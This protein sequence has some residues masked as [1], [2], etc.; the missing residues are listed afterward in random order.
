MKRV[1]IIS[2]CISFVSAVF[3]F[4]FNVP[5]AAPMTDTLSWLDPYNIV[6]T[7]PG[8]KSVNSMPIGGGN[9]SLNVWTTKDELLFY[10]GS[11][12]M[13]RGKSLMSS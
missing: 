12:E 10:I 6:W 4:T 5:P 11:S 7:T 3:G 13:C 9:I 2:I 1:I 8:N